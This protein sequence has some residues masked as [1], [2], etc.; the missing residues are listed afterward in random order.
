MTSKKSLILIGLLWIASLIAATTVIAQQ[1]RNPRP[2]TQPS[3]PSPAQSKPQEKHSVGDRICIDVWDNGGSFCGIIELITP[4]R[5]KVQLTTVYGGE[6]KMLL[7]GTYECEGL[8]P[9]SCSGDRRI[10]AK[11]YKQQGEAGVGDYVWIPKYCDGYGARLREERRAEAERRRIEEE[12][13]RAEKARLEAERRRTEE[14]SLKS[15]IAFANSLAPSLKNSI[16]ME[17]ILIKPGKFRMGDDAGNINEKPVREVFIKKPFYMGKYEVTQAQW[18][19][20]MDNNPSNFKGDDLPVDSV[21]FNDAKEFCGKLSR[22]TGQ[23]YRL[24]TEAEWEYACRAGTIAAIGLVNLDAMAWHD[25]N[26]GGKTHPVGRKQP[27]A[28]GLFDMYGNVWEWCEDVWHD[29][30]HGAPSDGSAWLSG[31]NSRN[32]VLRGGSWYVN[33]RNVSS[34]LRGSRIDFDRNVY[35]G[36]RVVVSAMAQ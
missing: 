14:E 13:R 12:R 33:S 23:E 28:F 7:V 3:L 22:M 15:A 36:F 2:A 21:S 31:G 34:T 35:S 16:G 9:T 29:S 4:E 20:V 25:G 6:C 30:Y 11:G 27:N 24:P 5:Y 8:S 19:E 32:R 10:R 26:S 1:H 18:R 17:L